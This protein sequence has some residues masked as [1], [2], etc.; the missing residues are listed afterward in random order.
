[1]ADIVIRHID[2][3]TGEFNGN[4]S[5]ILRNATLIIENGY[6]KCILSPEEAR[7]C[8]GEQLID[9]AVKYADYVLDGKGRLAAPG[10]VNTHTHI[11]MG[12]FRNYADDLE[13]MDWLA[14]EIW[15]AEAKLTGELATMGTQLGIAEMLRSG[16][17]CFNDMYFFMDEVA[18]VVKETGI[19]AVL[20]RGMA[21]VAPTAMQAL[22]ESSDLYNKWHGFD[23]SRI[24]VMLGPHAPY[25]CPDEY[26]K[27]V[28]DLA[29]ELGAQIHVHLCETKTEV[30]DVIKATGK[31][32]IAH[33]NDLG[34]FDVGCVAAHCVHV[35]D[36]DLRIMHEKNVRV[37]H[38]PQSNLKLASGIADLPV[39]LQQGLTVGLGTDGSASNNNAD[40]LEEVRL[41]AMLHKATHYDPKVIPAHTALALGTVEGAKVLDYQDLG[42][43]KEGYR[44]DIVLYDTTG[45]HW[46]PRYNDVASLVYA[47]NSSDVATTIVGG[48]ILMKDRELLTIDEE[49]L[50][51]QIQ[52]GTEIFR[53]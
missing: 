49:K 10:F 45:V 28:M 46:L 37:A 33:F 7:T 12:L 24:K 29:H 34:V 8:E 36:D 11:A 27:K 35:T 42:L 40:M 50:R 41:A 25:T 4:D 19:R 3:I 53:K 9:N 2:C 14:N 44:A 22:S 13:L 52:V 16:T 21:G 51:R 23:N 20:S 43:L 18:E 30:N 17:T 38:N 5:V 26:M 48:K 32:P 1:M 15:P 31:T 47:A 39:M 6:I